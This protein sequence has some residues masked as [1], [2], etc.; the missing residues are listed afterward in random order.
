MQEFFWLGEQVLASEEG[1]FFL[2]L[3]FFLMELVNMKAC[4]KYC[5]YE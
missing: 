4:N 1:L 3:F 2:L 5:V